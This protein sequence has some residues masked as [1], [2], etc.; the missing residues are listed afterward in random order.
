VCAVENGSLSA[1]AL[2]VI[3][4]VAIIAFELFTKSKHSVENN[5]VVQGL[6]LALVALVQRYLLTI[7]EA[8]EASDLPCRH[9]FGV[10]A[11]CIVAVV[12]LAPLIGRRIFEGASGER[13][14][15]TA[16]SKLLAESFERYL[17]PRQPTLGSFNTPALILNSTVVGHP[18]DESKALARTI[19]KPE[20]TNPAKPCDED[21]RPFKLMSGG[22]LIFTNLQDTNKFPQRESPIPDVRLPYQ[23]VKDLK[24]PLA[25][26]AALN[27]NFPPVFPNARIQ[28]ENDKPGSCKRSYYVTDGGAE[29]NLGLISALYAL[30]SAVD[31]IPSGVRIRPIHVVIAEASAVAYDYSQDRGLSVL[32]SWAL[33]HASPGGNQITSPGRISSTGPPQH[34]THPKPDVTINI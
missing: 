3:C 29:E 25:Y 27:A 6:V 19:D 23:I 33:R 26:A 2:L 30:E 17:F 9:V 11:P 1:F 12:A 28:F 16:L 18:A 32:P 10:W 22:R 31:K 14:R 24:V 21:E 7:S 5:V 4:I 34:C 8:W 13:E 20:L 15:F